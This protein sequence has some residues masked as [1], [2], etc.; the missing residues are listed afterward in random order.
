MMTCKGCYK[1][2]ET[3]GFPA[4]GYGFL[5]ALPVLGTISD[6]ETLAIP[7]RGFSTH[8]DCT[9]IGSASE[10]QRCKYMVLTSYMIGMHFAVIVTPHR[11]FCIFVLREFRRIQ[12]EMSCDQE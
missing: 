6:P 3:W 7:N 8:Y 9:S 11:T 10:P 4:G 2:L 1:S 12:R 5:E